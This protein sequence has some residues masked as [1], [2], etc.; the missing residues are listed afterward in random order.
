[1]VDIHTHRIVDLIP[2]RETDDVTEWLKSYPNIEVISRDGSASYHT[3]IKNAGEHICQVSDRFHLIKGITD[4]AKKFLIRLLG[5]N[6]VVPVEVSAHNGTPVGDYWD[7]ALKTDF[8]TKKHNTNLE[9]KIQL[10]E[11]VRELHKKGLNHAT[12]AKETR[13]H[14]V[15]VA[16]YLKKD[17]NPVSGTYNTTRPSKIKPYA[18]DIK[19]LLSEGK[20]FQQIHKYICEKGYNGAE[21]TLKMYAT[22]ERKLLKEA[23]MTSD[24]KT[25]KIERRWMIKLLYKP[26]EEVKELSRE[27][28][29][30][31]IGQYPVLTGLYEIV[32]RF[33]KILFSQKPDELERWIQEGELLG[34]EEIT[35]FING[36]KRDMEAVKNAVSMDYNNGLAEGSVNKL[37][38]VKR[39][40]YGRNSFELL[41][42]KL[43][44]LESKRGIN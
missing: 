2:S 1:M 20:T 27:K 21:S 4:A 8:P 23:G 13:I 10:V 14:R 12:I 40:M 39:I 6:F 28:L 37:K 22:R 19:R 33:E 11:K 43:L 18:E 5:A 25:E 42:S 3:A 29:D 32:Q 36:L 16:K 30:K 26:L 44:R 41:K 7:K 31:I 15:T 24:G 17:Y 38:V 9:K 34:I 35:S